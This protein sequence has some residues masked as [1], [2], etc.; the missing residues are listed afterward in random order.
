MKRYKSRV[1]NKSKYK[2]I[3]I[4]FQHHLKHIKFDKRLIKQ[5]KIFRYNWST[6]SDDYIDFLGSNLLGT[7][8]IRFSSI[9]DNK[10]YTEVYHLKHTDKIQEDIFDVYLMERKY[11]VASNLIYQILMYTANQFLHN[12]DLTKEERLEGVKEA[13]LIVQYKM[14]TSLYSKFFPYQVPENIATTT[15]NKLSHKFLIKRLNNWQEVF[16]Y[17]Y[18]KCV[19]KT[20]PGS[21]H[22]LRYDTKDSIDF[23]SGIQTKVRGNVKEVTAVFYKVKEND[24]SMQIESSTYVGGENNLEQLSDKTIGDSLYTNNLIAISQQ[25]NDFIDMET[26]NIVATTF[27]NILKDDILKFLRCMSNDEFIDITTLTKL[28]REILVL[29]FSYLKRND[30]NVEQR[31]TIPKALISIRYYWASSKVVNTDIS[32]IKK[33]L[34]K[35]A[36][37]CTGRKTNWYGITL[38][39]TYIVYVFLRSIKK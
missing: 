27:P 15:Y 2:N 35:K 4:F 26:V 14:F 38:A 10:L 30:I 11:K 12:K 5:L 20:I 8:S 16:L 36:K 7:Q 18:E 32:R 17:R 34:G 39:L 13:C 3:K 24:E 23:I 22:L 37:T 31:E 28:L 19:D 33:T 6:K 9:D 29:S 1:K 21:R 25:P